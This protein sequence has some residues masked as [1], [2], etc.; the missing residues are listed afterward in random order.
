MT[1]A[2][3]PL[4]R[5][6]AILAAVAI[7]GAWLLQGVDRATAQT[8]SKPKPVDGRKTVISGIKSYEAGR[9]D[10]AVATLTKAISGG[11]LS[12][13]DLAKALYYRG[14]A[15]Q[16]SKQ[17]A[18]AIADLTSAVWM[19]GGLSPSEQQEALAA[20]SKAY[21]AV[22]VSDPGPPTQSVGKPSPA[23]PPSRSAPAPAPVK[24]NQVAATV[25]STPQSAT[26]QSSGFQTQV[27][28]SSDSATAAS[29]EPAATT[30]NPLSGVGNFFSN[31]FSGGSTAPAPQ[32]PATAPATR[33]VAA[34]PVISTPVVAS[35]PVSAS[36]KTA[37]RVARVETPAAVL[38]PAQP[39]P[40]K[41][42]KPT[43]SAP[44]VQAPF[45][46][47][48]SRAPSPPPAAPPRAAPPPRVIS[49]PPSTPLNVAP[50][51]PPT[52][53]AAPSEEPS[54]RYEPSKKGVS[55]S[56]LDQLSETN[57]SV[58]GFFS[59]L[60][61]GGEQSSSASNQAPAGGPNTAV[62][63]WSSDKPGAGSSS[64]TQQRGVPKTTASIGRSR[65]GYKLQVADV[66]SRGEAE[67]LAYHLRQRHAAKMGGRVPNISEKVYGNMGT[68]YQVTVGP[69]AKTSDTKR[70]CAVLK[71]DGFDCQIVKN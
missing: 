10:T 36:A 25:K 63:A 66:R 60:F 18:Q 62:S 50:A 24:T 40:V 55:L 13:Q 20:R 31:I 51:T 17:S 64:A 71:A 45:E 67:R 54:R 6:L 42:K 23:A 38:A 47:T 65:G 58:G 70:V 48:L 35:P 19:K 22:G 5:F 46:T 59:N 52:I 34:A 1:S 3:R 69:F 49:T 11:G 28:K 37:P 44:P 61:G 41:P 16:R 7:G 27:T 68:F 9:M 30:S 12:S 29:A 57:N 56:A 8:V 39:A 4:L 14:L 2:V 33:P 43:V 21:A 32:P 53:A 26:P 15:H